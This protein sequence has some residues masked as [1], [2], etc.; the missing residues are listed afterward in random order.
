MRPNDLLDAVDVDDHAR[1]AVEIRSGVVAVEGQ[2]VIAQMVAVAAVGI[3]AAEAAFEQ[4]HPLAAIREHAGGNAAAGARSDDH[5][6][7]IEVVG[8]RGG[9]LP[10]RR[11]GSVRAFR[12]SVLIADHAPG[13]GAR[14]AAI[15]GIGVDVLGDEF[16]QK[17]EPGLRL[18]RTQD[19]LL[20]LGGAFD[21][22]GRQGVEAGGDDGRLVRVLAKMPVE[23]GGR[24]E[25]EGSAILVYRHDEGHGGQQQRVVHGSRLRQ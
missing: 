14:I 19:C 8:H 11:G 7:E 1:I 18:A 21:E 24:A 3:V 9:R 20:R 17:L 6:V 15:V 22:I 4:Q 25:F 2:S 13:R 23:I 10:S 12:Q 5:H 16:G